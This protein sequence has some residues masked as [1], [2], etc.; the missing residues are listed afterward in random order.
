MH[1]RW[2]LLFLSEPPPS[3]MASWK[4][5]LGKLSQLKDS[6]TL[7]VTVRKHER[8]RCWPGRGAVLD[9]DDSGELQWPIRLCLCPT[10]QGQ[11][12]PQKE[13]YF[14]MFLFLLLILLQM[15]LSLWPSPHYCLWIMYICYLDN[16]LTFFYPDTSS[17]F[18]PSPV[19]DFRCALLL[20]RFPCKATR[21][22]AQSP[23][24]LHF[25]Q[26]PV[27]ECTRSAPVIKQVEFITWVH[28]PWVFRVQS[29]DVRKDLL[30]LGL[31]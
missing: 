3:Q 23:Q 16:P 27:A 24:V 20:L 21:I 1:L 8:S 5:S 2:T 18:L 7:N 22:S 17:P 26:C 12:I 25:C 6:I 4:L 31:S 9:W 29:A 15:S 13:F 19:R 11:V 28:T 14:L 10:C 30:D